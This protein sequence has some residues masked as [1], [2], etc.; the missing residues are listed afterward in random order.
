MPEYKKYDFFEETLAISRLLEVP[1]EKVILLNLVYE[2][3]ANEDCFS[4]FS[5]GCTAIILKD[6]LLGTLVM[7]RIL[8]YSF[9][10]EYS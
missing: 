2:I 1:H 7:G 6:E 5:L 9:Q 3:F 4:Y 8:D 10:Q